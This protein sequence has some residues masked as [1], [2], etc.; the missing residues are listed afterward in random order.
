[1]STSPNILDKA[2]NDFYSRI[3]EEWVIQIGDKIE[4]NAGTVEEILKSKLTE[5]IEMIIKDIENDI[6]KEV[7]DRLFYEDISPLFLCII[8]L[9]AV[10]MNKPNIDLYVTKLVNDLS[11]LKEKYPLESNTN[12]KK[13]LIEKL[14]AVL[15][16][17]ISEP[18]ESIQD[19]AE[20]HIQGGQLTDNDNAVKTVKGEV[21][22]TGEA[23][24]NSN[25]DANADANAKNEAK[26]EALAEAK[27]ENQIAVEEEKN[28]LKNRIK[29]H[30]DIENA[31]PEEVGQPIDNDTP[32][33][34]H[35]A[36][37]ETE[38]AVFYKGITKLNKETKKI[39][40]SKILNITW[41]YMKE[42]AE[43]IITNKVKSFIYKSIKCL[44]DHKDELLLLSLLTETNY[45]F[46][47]DISSQIRRIKTDFNIEFFK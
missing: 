15:I 29:L 14:K 20:K 42:K 45:S 26:D 38:P 41:T 11:S 8:G 30:S 34:L 6:Y 9:S 43:V 1:M 31:K 36:S 21:K 4:E 35:I 37:K 7:F 19:E 32:M 39:V 40:R 17:H 13:E 23:L 10:D 16:V 47:P 27:D 33:V 44:E 25:D 2:I 3:Q 12:K 46:A 18:E 24:A 22:L 28:T 5:F